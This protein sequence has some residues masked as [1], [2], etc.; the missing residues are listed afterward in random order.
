MTKKTFAVCTLGCKVNAYESECLAALFEKEGL[1][2]VDFSESADIY[3]INTCSVTNTGDKKSRQAIR[4]ARRQNPSAFIAVCGCYAQASA[5]EVAASGADLVCGTSDREKLVARAI[6]GISG[7]IVSDIRGKREFEELSEKPVTERCR[8]YI[9]I[10]DGCN[11]FCSYCIIPYTRGRVRSRSRDSVINEAIR[12][13]EEGFSEIVLAGIEV[14]SYGADTGTSSLIGL[15]E[16]LS[17]SVNIPR[18]RLSSIDPRAFTDDF[19]ARLSRIRGLCRHFH[20]S[21]Q[22]GCD[23]TLKRMN[24]PNTAEEFLTILKKL[25]AAMP[26]VAITTDI[27]TGFPGET[28]EE[29]AKTREFIKKAEFSRLHVFPY[30]ERSGTRAAAMEQLPVHLR[31]ERA[32]ILIEDGKAYA[33][34]FAK[35]Q[36]G[37]TL[38]VLAEYAKDGV[39]SGYSENYVRVGFTGSDIKVG[40]IYPVLA[41]KVLSDG[42][43]SGRIVKEK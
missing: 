12:L 6:A 23:E 7:S 33:V 17:S 31:S 20:I 24:R 13:K 21:A 3:L 14:Y 32:K 37:K 11:N 9:K 4:K 19:I 34:N 35:K 22:S 42:S 41:E 8:A 29:F 38:F 18:I 2:K 36:L 43:L 15:L 27:I 5:D 10:Q 28:E 25:R 1:T 39:Y 30:S 40:N 26:G 16:E